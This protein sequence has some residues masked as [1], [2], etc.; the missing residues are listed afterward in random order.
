MYS[1]IR[2]LC[3]RDGHYMLVEDLQDGERKAE[4]D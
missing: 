4:K 3:Q 2:D 1:Y